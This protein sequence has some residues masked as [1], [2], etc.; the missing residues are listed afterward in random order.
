MEDNAEHMQVAVT[1]VDV[2]KDFKEEI[3]RKVNRH[4]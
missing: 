3:A 2:L 1:A 4:K